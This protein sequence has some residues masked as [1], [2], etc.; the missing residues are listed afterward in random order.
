MNNIKSVSLGFGFFIGKISIEPFLPHK[1]ITREGNSILWIIRGLSKFT[2]R[3]PASWL[4]AGFI[5]QVML[6][7]TAL[8]QRIPSI[9]IFHETGYRPWTTHSFPTHAVVPHFPNRDVNQ[10]IFKDIAQTEE[11]F[12]SPSPSLWTSTVGKASFRLARK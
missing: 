1:N 2:V 11:D 3:T 12:T 6:S 5:L 4:S 7:N 8:L 10:F 9:L